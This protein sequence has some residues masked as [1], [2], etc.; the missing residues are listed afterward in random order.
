M[1]VGDD[2]GG[3]G[4]APG[5]E[6]KSEKGCYQAQGA[7]AAGV[8]CAATVPGANPLGSCGGSQLAMAMM[9]QYQQN[10]QY[11][12]L[13]GF[14]QEGYNSFGQF[15]SFGSVSNFG[16]FPS[17]SGGVGA[18]GAGAGGSC[19]AT[20]CGGNSGVGVSEDGGC[21]PGG[22]NSASGS[23]CAGYPGCGGYGASGLG[24]IASLYQGL[25]SLYG[26]YPQA[27]AGGCWQQQQ[28]QLQQSALQNGR[29]GFESMR[30][31]SGGSTANMMP[32]DWMCPV[33]SDHVF[34]RNPACRRCG[35]PKPENAVACSL[36]G[37]MPP[38]AGIS[39]NQRA[40]PGDWN[41]PRCKDLQFARNSQC[42]M[43][44]CPKP[45]AGGFDL[46]GG[47][48]GS[49]S[50]GCAGSSAAVATLVDERKRSASRSRSRRSR[51][52]R[53]RS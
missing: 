13:Q 17:C 30:Q 50:G 47:Q 9:Q 53:S 27:A 19:P 36:G 5:T 40:L 52:R 18:G 12:Q 42:R 43:C 26:M 31:G 32:G 37:A 20:G 34:A 15:P 11:P 33:C 25:Y 49:V 51:K 45:D 38:R 24:S 28:Q 48:G 44:G 14:G 3:G 23:G 35:A 2:S 6:W 1:P 39:N 21:T 22:C 4:Y 16:Q 10:W 46:R 7:S 29:T 8:G 41:C